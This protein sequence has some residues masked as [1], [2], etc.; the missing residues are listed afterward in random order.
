[1]PWGFLRRLSDFAQERRAPVA[2]CIPADASLF[3]MAKL[4]TTPA[5]LLH[6]V[7]ATKRSKPAV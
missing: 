2:H 1:V 6:F 5:M 7:F 4:R 3:L